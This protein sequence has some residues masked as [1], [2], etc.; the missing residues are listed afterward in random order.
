MTGIFSSVGNGAE[1]RSFATSWGR[2]LASPSSFT[3]FKCVKDSSPAFRVKSD[4][5]KIIKGINLFVQSDLAIKI[6][7]GAPHILYAI[8]SAQF[9]RVPSGNISRQILLAFVE[10]YKLVMPFTF[11]E[12]VAVFIKPKPLF[13]IDLFGGNSFE[14]RIICH[15]CLVSTTD[16]AGRQNQKQKDGAAHNIWINEMVLAN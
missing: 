6:L 3:N 13:C 10:G 9:Y 4:P 1:P 2:G 15:V 16:Q 14:T 11:A 12:L 8:D 7:P 5:Q